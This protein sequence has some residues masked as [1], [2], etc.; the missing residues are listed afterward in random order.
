MPAPDP[1]PRP[2][3]GDAAD[4]LQSLFGSAPTLRVDPSVGV[5]VVNTSGVIEFANDRA[6]QMFLGMTSDEV[7][8]RRL[9]ELFDPEWVRER[10]EWIG[11]TFEHARPIVIRSIRRGVQVQSTLHPIIDGGIGQVLVT[12]VEG[13]TPSEVHPEGAVIVE[14]KVIDLGPLD[15]LSPRELEVLA[16]IGQGLS[17]GEIAAVLHRSVRTIEKHRQ[18][19]SRKLGEA[20]RVVLGQLARRA[21]LTLED[22]ERQRSRL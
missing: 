10:L 7:V 20:S 9:D 18:S 8:G 5:S 11:D 19:L 1:S 13:R 14:S 12:S 4:R 6:A 16:L 2:E 15:V 17:Q 3:P 22:A 21:G